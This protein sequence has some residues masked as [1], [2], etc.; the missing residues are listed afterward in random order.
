VID[1]V[2]LSGTH[3]NVVTPGGVS[4]TFL[5]ALPV[6]RFFARPVVYPADFG[7]PVPY[8]DSR[9]DGRTAALAVIRSSSNLVLLGGYSQGAQIAGD[10]AAE[11]STNPEL[12]ML[13]GKIVACALIAD[14]S[15]PEG[16]GTDDFPATGYGIEGS[17]EVL[18]PVFW[19]TAPGDPIS[20]LPAGN[21]LRTIADLTEFW[22]SDP[23]AWARWGNAMI[24]EI[25]HKRLQ[26]WWSIKNWRTWGSALAY[27]RGYVFDGRHTDAYI[28]EGHAVK[29]AQ[30]VSERVRE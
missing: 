9:S 15:R 16:A 30:I 3:E 2:W 4:A 29:L 12:A 14:P 27:M 17:R 7:F 10:L 24:S 21:A 25:K 1:V 8:C 13:R 5:A 11:I 20:A 19:A 22:S 18:P 6:D 28:D 23:L 26:R